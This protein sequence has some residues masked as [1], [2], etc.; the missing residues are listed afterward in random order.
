VEHLLLPGGQPA[1][2]DMRV[3][4]PK[5]KQALKKEQ[6]RGPDCSRSTEPG[7]D[8]LGDYRLHLN[9]RNELRKIAAAARSLYA[10]SDSTAERVVDRP[11]TG[12]V[13][14]DISRSDRQ[15]GA[16]D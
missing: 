9:S 13:T 12:S 11:S 2:Q 3:K 14:A 10:R 7:E 5:E 6:A 15:S 4:I 8:L 16:M 1:E